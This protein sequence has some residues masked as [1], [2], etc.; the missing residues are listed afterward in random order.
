MF[1]LADLINITKNNN[2]SK[3][4]GIEFFTFLKVQIEARL[5]RGFGSGF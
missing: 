5:E 2:S 3:Y 4:Q 1:L